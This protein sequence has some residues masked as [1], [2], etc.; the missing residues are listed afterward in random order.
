MSSE[1]WIRPLFLLPG[2]G[3]LVMSTAARYSRLHEELHHVEE[4]Q[5]RHG[6]VMGVLF[7]RARLFRDSLV[8]LY[9]AAAILALG[10]LL[11]GLASSRAVWQ[12]WIVNAA[13]SLAVVCVLVACTQLIRESVHSLHVI[14]EHALRDSRAP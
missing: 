8:A 11:G 13:T 3:L 5:G 14:R 10:P 12:E 9:L 1:L 2:V 7:L 6:D 4:H